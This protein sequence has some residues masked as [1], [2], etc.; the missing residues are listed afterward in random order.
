MISRDY[1]LV[2]ESE[3]EARAASLRA[4][5]VSDDEKCVNEWHT[6]RGTPEYTQ[7]RSTLSQNKA[8]KDAIAA[9][10]TSQRAALAQQQRAA[11]SNALIQASK[12]PPPS[13]TLNC[14]STGYG[15]TVRTNCY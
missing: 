15:N 7:C 5:Y 10:S 4:S 8:Q 12:S 11:I 14:T 2:P 9:Q 13:R 6:K 3:A 1:L